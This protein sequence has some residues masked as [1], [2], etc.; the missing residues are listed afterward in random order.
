MICLVYFFIIEKSDCLHACLKKIYHLYYGSKHQLKNCSLNGP[1]KLMGGPDVTTH[2]QAWL[3][4][5]PKYFH[6]N[7]MPVAPLAISS[8]L[9]IFWF[10]FVGVVLIVQEIN[11][12]GGGVEVVSEGTEFYTSSCSPREAVP[13][14]NLW[15]TISEF[16]S[17]LT[18]A[19]ML[20]SLTFN[21]YRIHLLLRDSYFSLFSKL[22]T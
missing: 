9:H 3:K 16:Y 22:F 8:F 12:V 18:W 6:I 10:I 11:F 15:S 14:S 2:H 1:N 19:A 13:F 7:T 21:P 17:V 5:L 4:S 20:K